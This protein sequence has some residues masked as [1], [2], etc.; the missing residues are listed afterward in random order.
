MTEE[1]RTMIG[2]ASW[3]IIRE[4]KDYPPQII[5]ENKDPQHIHARHAHQKGCDLYVSPAL[6]DMIENLRAPV[7]IDE[8]TPKESLDNGEPLDTRILVSRLAEI[9]EEVIHIRERM[10]EEIDGGDETSAALWGVT[11]NIDE[12][13][14]A[15]L[16][17]THKAGNLTFSSRT[18]AQS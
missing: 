2:S 18:A 9:K 12:T 3:K 11:S 10:E 15:V 13:V 4:D 17:A 5:I 7:V 6:Y 14:G 1:S 16:L 8:L